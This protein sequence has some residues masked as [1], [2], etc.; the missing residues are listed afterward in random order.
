MA[1]DQLDVEKSRERFLEERNHSAEDQEKQE[2]QEGECNKRKWSDPSES[3]PAK[4]AQEVP[5]LHH[6]RKKEPE[7]Q[8][9]IQNSLTAADV[10][11]DIENATTEFQYDI[12]N[13]VDETPLNEDQ[14]VDKKSIPSK[15][16]DK[17]C[18]KDNGKSM[19]LIQERKG[20]ELTRLS[21][22][23]RKEHKK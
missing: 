4:R 2:E 13:V 22:P 8:H 23:R 20:K 3:N 17:K 15:N 5:K 14:V 7:E 11:G 10:Q 19:K 1:D 6:G 18:Q 9:I 12:G 21:C 16:W